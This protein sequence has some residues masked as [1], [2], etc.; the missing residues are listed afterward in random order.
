MSEKI[1]ILHISDIHRNEEG[2]VKN[3]ALLNSLIQD[4]EAYTK[5][6]ISSPDLIIVSGDIVYGS[7][8]SNF[9]SAIEEIEEQ[10]IEAEEFLNMLV[11]EFLGG[12]KQKIIIVPGNHDVCLPQ[13]KKSLKEIDVSMVDSQKKTLIIKKLF[14][15]ESNIRWSWKDLSFYE[16]TD[17]LEYNKR[18][19][20]FKQFYDKFYNGIQVFS[21]NPEEQFNI[22]DC[23][24]LG[25]S[26]VAF[27]SCFNND[28][29]NTMGAIN[30][31]CIANS[32]NKIQDYIKKGRFIIGTWHHNVKGSPKES[33]YMD[34]KVLK[35]LMDY[36]IT[37]G[38][39]GHQHQLEKIDDYLNIREDKKITLISAGTL[40]AGP[41]YLPIGINRQYN[42]LEIFTETYKARLHSRKMMQ[43]INFSLP[44]WEKEN[45]NG[46]PMGYIEFQLQKPTP[47]KI[48]YILSKAIDLMGNKDFLGAISLLEGLDTRG[49]DV[50]NLLIECYVE[51]NDNKGLIGFIG[52]PTNEREVIYLLHALYSERDKVKLKEVLNYN[53]VKALNSPSINEIKTRCKALLI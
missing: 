12:D 9:D 44:I 27:N 38:F 25:I 5:E 31:S 41:N 46:C 36:G 6:N 52:E 19:L 51:T 3:R 26:I 18:F 28:L 14:E 4:K 47:P 49:E 45:I 13:L 30:P 20:L 48:D 40:C 17:I 29:F 22:F 16:I 34:I 39:H 11:D 2:K 42:I 33:N 32:F 35:N 53:V 7:T 50:R 24:S 15:E 37:L 43:N 1:T 8:N 23:N 21:L 10:Y